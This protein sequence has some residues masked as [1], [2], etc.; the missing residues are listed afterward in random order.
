VQL[1]K[2][3]QLTEGKSLDIRIEAFNVFNHADPD[4]GHVVSAAAPRLVQAALKFHF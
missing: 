1:S 4:F 3:V 2:T